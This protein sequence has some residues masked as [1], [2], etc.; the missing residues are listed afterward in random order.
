MVYH[1]RRARAA[2][3][4]LLSA[5][6]GCGAGTEPSAGA[7]VAGNWVLRSVDGGSLPAAA[8][9]WTGEVS[10]AL[11]AGTLTLGD[12]ASYRTETY[13]CVREVS[14]TPSPVEEGDSQ[15]RSLRYAV[16]GRTVVL[17]P[18]YGAPAPPPPDTAVWDG[19]D[20]LTVTGTGINGSRARRVYV[21]GRR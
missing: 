12:T 1:T 20:A 21:Y 6:T 14:T 13:R 10:R 18:L 15:V 11:T 5:A 3:L 17:Y 2:L 19:A 8:D 4:L 16:R 7:R 9:P